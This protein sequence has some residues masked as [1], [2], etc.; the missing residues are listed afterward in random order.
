[1]FSLDASWFPLYIYGFLKFIL[2]K[3]IETKPY[4]SIFGLN[5]WYILMHT[6][7]GFLHHGLIV[8]KIQPLINCMH[9]VQVYDKTCTWLIAKTSFVGKHCVEKVRIRNY[10]GVRIFPHSDYMRENADQNNSEYGHFLCI[11]GFLCWAYCWNI[12]ILSNRSVAS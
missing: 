10:S 8:Y 1:M 7:S 12:M 6:S 5:P 9:S 11:E 2:R 3:S 4:F